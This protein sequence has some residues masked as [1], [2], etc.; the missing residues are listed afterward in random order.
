MQILLLR[1]RKLQILLLH[2]RK[3]QILFCVIEELLWLNIAN[4][5]FCI[6]CDVK[7]FSVM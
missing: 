3:L 4:I 5:F 2:H 1:H 6:L 7:M